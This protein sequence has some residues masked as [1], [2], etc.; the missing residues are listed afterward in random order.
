MANSHKNMLNEWGL[1]LTILHLSKSVFNRNHFPSG[2][3]ISNEVSVFTYI[4]NGQSATESPTLKYIC[5]LVNMNPV[6]I[7]LSAHISETS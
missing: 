6:H 7:L 1:V 2:Y 5:R 3:I 4:T